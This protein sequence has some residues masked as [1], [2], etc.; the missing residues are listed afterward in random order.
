MRALVTANIELP[1]IVERE[2]DHT[3]VYL[4]GTKGTAVIS[5]C[6]LKANGDLTAYSGGTP[7]DLEDQYTITHGVGITPVLLVTGADGTTSIDVLALA[8]A[9]KI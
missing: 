2:T 5:I 3:I 6:Y 8:L 9:A 7:L 1:L 4:S